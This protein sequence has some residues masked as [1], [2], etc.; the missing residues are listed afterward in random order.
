MSAGS[1]LPDWPGIIPTQYQ[2]RL[3]TRV[4]LRRKLSTYAEALSALNGANRDRVLAAFNEENTI[5]KLLSCSCEC[6]SIDKLPNAI[7]QPVKDLFAYSFSLLSPLGIRDKFYRFIFEGMPYRV[8][9]FCGVEYFDPPGAPREPLDHYLAQARYPFAAAN[10]KNLVPM[11]HKCNSKYKLSQD[12]LRKKNGD[13]RKS[14]Y[15]YAAGAGVKITLSNSVPFNGKDG[16]MPHWRIEFRRS[17][18]EVE[19]WDEVFK[20]RERY[21]RDILDQDYKAWLND[22]GTWCRVRNVE[23]KTRASLL[24]ALREFAKYHEQLGLSD[25]SFLKAAV[26]RMLVRRCMRGD[27]RLRQLLQDILQ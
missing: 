26:F 3:V 6:E 25:R 21:A 7:R 23:V 8:C 22:F 4:G 20:I 9:A 14:F 5:R 10:I 15:P 11:G 16:Q 27:E 19:T 2:S 13:R 12:I 17:G 1:P 18:E 24:T